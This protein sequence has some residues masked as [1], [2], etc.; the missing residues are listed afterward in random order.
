MIFCDNEQYR[1]KQNELEKQV[2]D[3]ARVVIFTDKSLN[4]FNDDILFKIH[5]IAEEIGTCR[6]AWHSETNEMVK[7]F[8]LTAFRDFYNADK[9]YYDLASW[10]KFDWDGSEE[11][12][13]TMVDESA[14]KY[15]LHKKHKN[16]MA[17]KKFGKGEV[18]LTTLTALKGCIGHNPYLDKLII[19]LIEK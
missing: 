7:E 9:D 18:V 10:F 12:L 15:V 8:P 3:G 11:I 13:Y 1:L 6:T 2:L 5:V 17:V 4:V 16:I 14:D 19:N